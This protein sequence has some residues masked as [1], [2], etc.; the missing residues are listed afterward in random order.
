ML[1]SCAERDNI[2]AMEQL[3]R[4]FLLFFSEESRTVGK[5]LIFWAWS[6]ASGVAWELLCKSMVKN[7]RDCI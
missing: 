6:M 4:V 1:Y 3:T 5:I 2:G 7:S